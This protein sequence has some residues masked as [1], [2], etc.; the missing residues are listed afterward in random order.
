MAQGGRRHVG[1]ALV[2][3]PLSKAREASDLLVLRFARGT[4]VDLGVGDDPPLVA[5]DRLIVLAPAGATS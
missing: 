4:K 3:Q 2:S 1:Q 5:G